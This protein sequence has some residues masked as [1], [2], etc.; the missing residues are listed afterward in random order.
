MSPLTYEREVTDAMASILATR[1]SSLAPYPATL[2]SSHLRRSQ[3]ISGDPK[4]FPARW[5]IQSE[6]QVIHSK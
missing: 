2:P 3:H 6:H 5:P 4:L 1:H